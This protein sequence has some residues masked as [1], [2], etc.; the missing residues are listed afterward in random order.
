MRIAILVGF[1]AQAVLRNTIEELLAH[2]IGDALDQG[3]PC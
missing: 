2:Q 3:A 1:I